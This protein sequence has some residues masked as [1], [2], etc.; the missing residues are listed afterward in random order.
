MPV[1][2]TCILNDMTGSEA[3]SCNKDLRPS[4][5][6]TVREQGEHEGTRAA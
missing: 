1:A 6:I 3:I 5:R 2:E 4:A